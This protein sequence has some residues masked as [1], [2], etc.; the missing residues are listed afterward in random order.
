MSAH[1]T[2]EEFL[3]SWTAQAWSVMALHCQKT[4]LEHQYLYAKVAVKKEA[5]AVM[6]QYFFE[7]IELVAFEIGESTREMECLVDIP[8]QAAVSVGGQG[9]VRHLVVR[10]IKEV[11]PYKPSPDGD[12]GVNPSSALRE[13]TPRSEPIVTNIPESD[14]RVNDGEHEGGR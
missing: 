1:D 6:L 10:L 5:P 12:W 11:A 2:L 4:W 7:V 3:T 14:R 8:V 9:G 13:W